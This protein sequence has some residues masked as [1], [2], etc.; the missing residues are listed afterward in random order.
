M[1]KVK[2]INVLSVLLV[3]S[4]TSF[5]Y[6]SLDQKMSNNNDNINIHEKS[7][8]S[9][10]IKAES[11]NSDQRILDIFKEQG[12]IEAELFIKL[13]E[14]VQKKLDLDLYNINQ[15]M[16]KNALKERQIKK[17]KELL[18]KQ[19]LARQKQISDYVGLLEEGHDPLDIFKQAIEHNANLNQRSN[20][21]E[22]LPI[23]VLRH[24][25]NF[26]SNQEFINLIKY[27]V[28]DLG[29]DIYK[30]DKEGYSLYNLVRDNN[31]QLAQNLYK[32]YQS[33]HQHDQ[34]QDL[35]DDLEQIVRDD[36]FSDVDIIENKDNEDRDFL[37][38][39]KKLKKHTH[40]KKW[41][42]F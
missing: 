19:R 14:E 10:R 24:L 28:Q 2:K 7:D 22:L 30:I 39:E 29:Y 32:M 31:L 12:Y 35:G 26:A 18:E 1:K 27:A 36:V 37:L 4:M 5:L 11:D 25:S 15:F 13:S 34:E 41:Y 6:S 8:G 38:T 3:L 9:N 33:Q 17:E 42:W 16:K 23:Y 21:G 40:P 20:K